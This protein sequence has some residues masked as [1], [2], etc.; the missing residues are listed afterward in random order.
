MDQ[1]FAFRTLKS[2]VFFVFLFSLLGMPLVQAQWNP[3]IATPTTSIYREGKVGI[4]MTTV[5]YSQLHVTQEILDVLPGQEIGVIPTLRLQRD[6]NTVFNND[7]YTWDFFPNQ[8][9]T[10]KAGDGITSE[11][12]LRISTIALEAAGKELVLG[13]FNANTLD[14]MTITQ[15]GFYNGY[16]LGFNGTY[17]SG[18]FITGP[19]GAGK[20]V[21]QSST[22]G[23]LYFITKGA[24]SAIGPFENHRLTLTPDGEAIIGDTESSQFLKVVSKSESILQLGN[25]MGGDNYEILRNGDGLLEFRGGAS[26]SGSALPQLMLLNDDGELM[27]GTDKSPNSLDGGTT[28]LSAYH[29]Y[30]AGGILTEEVRVRTGWADHVFEADYELLPL[31]QVKTHI[32]THGHLHNTPSAERIENGGLELGSMT[33][34]QQE[35]IEEIF[36]HLIDLKEKVNALEAENEALKQELEALNQ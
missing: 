8:G 7:T 19:A 23:S 31:E 29:L 9:L 22:D 35:K 10:L 18:N 15:N 12:A 36:L 25:S 16:Y 33:V 28:D 5:P 4:G 17:S 2:H 11:S 1:F 13:H 26:G 21:I 14:R 30:V 6:Y 34:N 32:K 24:G 20:A 27:I 3:T